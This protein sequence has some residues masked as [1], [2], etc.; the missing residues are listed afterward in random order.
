MDKLFRIRA[1]DSIFRLVLSFTS[2]V[3]VVIIFRLNL[4]AD[5][6]KLG[7]LII[8]SMLLMVFAVYQLFHPVYL[9]NDGIECFCFKHLYRKILWNQID[10]VYQLTD[11]RH[12]TGTSDLGRFVIVPIGCSRYDKKKWF[13]LQ[14]LFVF[15]KQVVWIDNTKKNRQ[16]IEKHYGKIEE[17]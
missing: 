5:P 2:I 14:Y 16:I 13:G 7:F 15:R 6:V 11:F 1:I 8:A 3:A 10:C 4:K 17:A 12:S 9:T